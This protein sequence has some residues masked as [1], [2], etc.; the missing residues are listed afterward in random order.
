MRKTC[1]EKSLSK[2]RVRDEQMEWA[3]T[4][5]VHDAIISMW[6]Q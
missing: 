1:E 5:L 6:L 4:V 3:G 2:E